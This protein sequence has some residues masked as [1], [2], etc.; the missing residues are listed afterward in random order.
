MNKLV[1]ISLLVLSVL[2]SLYAIER[3]DEY[4]SNW[5]EWRGPLATGISPNGNP[6]TEWSETQNIKWKLDVPGRGHATPIVWGNQ[7]ILLTAIETGIKDTGSNIQEKASGGP[8]LVAES[9]LNFSVLSVDIKDGKTLWQTTVLEE[10]P[11]DGTHELGS[12]ASNSPVT[13]GEH[14]YAYFGSRGIYCLNMQGKLIWKK[15]F[16]KM[17]KVRSFGEG[18]SPVLYKNML[19][20]VWDHEGDSFIVALDKLT[21]KELWK[22]ERDE[23]SSW[24]TPFVVTHEGMDQLI[25][26]ATNFVRSY[27]PVNG[28]ILWQCSGLTRNVIPNPLYLDGI[29]YVMSGYRGNALLAID[30]N[31]AS[32]DI[33]GT[34]AIV[35]QYDKNTP[36]TPSPVL[37][38][39]MIYMLRANNGKL[40]CLDAKSGNE[41]YTLENLE[42][43]GNVYSSLMGVQDRIYVTGLNGTFYVIKASSQFEVIAKNTL[44][45]KFEASPVVIGKTLLLRGYENL[46]CIE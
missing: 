33:T 45:D 15:D 3:S 13:D 19:F 25:T 7:V 22:K 42:G 9:I 14:I 17:E 39:N 31:K 29:V 6:P 38:N 36:Y 40:S 21:G 44:D 11:P 46:Y 35:W 5:P 12:W 32:G 26:S 24:A 23:G 34:D 41:I 28:E 18:S 27:N 1:M 43:A 16:G 20:I 37:M 2:V 30:L 8:P 4:L 10:Q